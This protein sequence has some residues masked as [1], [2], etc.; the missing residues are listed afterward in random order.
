MTNPLRLSDM[1]D[2][3]R[4]FW[5][6]P[7]PTYT[8]GLVRIAFGALVIAWSLSLLTGLYEFFGADGVSHP[9]DVG[10]YRWS[11]FEIWTSG[12]VL[13][14]GWVI[15]LLAAIALTIGW[16][17]RIA[18]IVVFILILSFDRRNPTVFNSGDMLIRIEAL[19]LALSP[20]GAAL[21]LDQRRRMGDFWSA[22]V[23]PRWPIRL[24]QCQVSLIYLATVNAKL[25][26]IT[27]PQGTAVSYA[28]RLEDMVL[29][30]VPDF[31]RL[32]ALLMNA[33]TWGTLVLEFAIAILVWNRAVRPW[34]LAAGIL[35]H[36]GI[37]VTMAVGFFTLAVFV[38]YIAFIP[39]ET[40]GRLVGKL[41]RSGEGPYS[42]A[43]ETDGQPVVSVP[44]DKLPAGDGASSES[45]SIRSLFGQRLRPASTP[46]RRAPPRRRARAR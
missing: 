5:F 26:G 16:H 27:W 9:G 34:V 11:V 6:R 32:N 18:S 44:V 43:P 42:A 30:P 36:T 46:P 7:E 41:R 23:R 25:S 24:L 4:T 13:L 1:S 40:V 33:A 35:M 21:S 39:P 20:C 31:I 22:Q 2:A 8:L 10:P 28:L 45:S 19:F 15:L 17:S 37:M 38:L 3:W 12:K 29:L 14:I